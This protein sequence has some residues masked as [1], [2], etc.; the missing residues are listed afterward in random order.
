MSRRLTETIG[1][2]P[3]DCPDG[4][5]WVISVDPESGKAEKIRGNPEHPFTQGGLCKK[6]NPW[7]TFASDPGRLTTPLRRVGAKGSGEFEAISWEVALAEIASRFASTRDAHGGEAIWPFYGTGNVGFVQGVAGQPGHRLFDAL[8]ASRHAATICSVSGHIGISYTAGSA[9]GLEP[10]TV[11][12]AKTVLIWGS[13]TL[14]A[15]QHWWPFVDEARANGATIVVIDPIRTRTAERADIHLALRPGTDGA[16]AL[17]LCRFLVDNDLIDNEFLADRTTGF[18]EFRESLGPW[19]LAATAAE[20]GIEEAAIEA[21]GKLLGA[22]GAVA[23]KLGQ[24]MQRQAY[25]GQAAR[26]VSCLPALLGSY[27]KPGG[28]LVYST[29]DSYA[30]NTGSQRL[31]Q[32]RSLAM[33]NLAS[34]LNELSDPPV[35]AM[36]MLGANPMVSNPDINGVER[37]LARDD[38]FTVV[39]DI[40]MTETAAYADIVLPSTM[41]HEQFELNDSFAHTILNWNEPA[42]SPPGDCLSH[43]EMFRRLA[44]VMGIEDPIA[45]ASDEEIIDRLLDSPA[46]REVGLSRAVLQTNGFAQMPVTDVSPFAE[47]FPTVSGRFEFASSRADDDGH[48]R[49]PNYRPMAETGDTGYVLL[50]IASD[51][52]IN[53]VFAG[54]DKTRS[55]TEA[56]HLTMHPVD[57]EAEGVSSGDEVVVSNARGEVAMIADVADTTRRGV[58][59]TTKGWWTQGLNRTVADRDSDM[60][61]GAVFHDNRVQV[62]TNR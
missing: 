10:H 35:H 44:R 39:V 2:C 12:N 38:L 25:G 22:D 17:G 3:L 49:L 1:A 42:V 7:L 16:L 33:T 30:L 20:C 55:R 36:M 13:N 46:L 58:V 61:R 24:G 51:W 53:S 52:H 21:V 48:G 19:D 47:R 23:I 14:T 34:N 6:V 41:Q 5:S 40:Y 29:S 11:V 4:C 57:A 43:T 62:R 56:P 9:F 26:V 18:D 15:N 27:G 8:G 37:G 31:S 50:A 32:T 54:T 28:G 59:S 45:Y 60:G